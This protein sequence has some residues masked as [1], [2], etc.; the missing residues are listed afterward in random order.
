MLTIAAE[1]GAPT[2]CQLCPPSTVRATTPSGPPAYATAP[3]AGASVT[4]EPAILLP[5]GRQVAPASSEISTLPAAPAAIA[6]VGEA[7][8]TAYVHTPPTVSAV[9]RTRDMRSAPIDPVQHIGHGLQA[10]DL[11]VERGVLRKP[12]RPLAIHIFRRTGWRHELI[13]NLSDED[14]ETLERLEPFQPREAA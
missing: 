14:M 2:L 5:I 11:I 10:L 4:K 9:R 7:S 12:S 13:A 1:V 8:S 6:R 3:D